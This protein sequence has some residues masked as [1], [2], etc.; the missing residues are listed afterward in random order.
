MRRWQ[1]I[2]LTLGVAALIFAAQPAQAQVWW[3]PPGGNVQ[4]I[5]GRPPPQQVWWVN[6][7]VQQP[8]PPIGMV[9][10]PVWVAPGPVVVN[11]NWR[12]RPWATRR[13]Y[14]QWARRW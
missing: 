2:A 10:G 5:V 7:P 13:A 1:P 6:S 14:R 12:G 4:V 8:V 9:P 11:N 3:G